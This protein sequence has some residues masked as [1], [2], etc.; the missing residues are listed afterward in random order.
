MGIFNTAKTAAT[1]TVDGIMSAFH[2]TI[3]DLEAV[4]QANIEAAN[5]K[6]EAAA[7]LITESNAATAEA[8]RANA[9][10]AKLRGIVEA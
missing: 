6:S 4:E 5:E 2:K 9:I 1:K 3:S 10:A 7:R 8:K